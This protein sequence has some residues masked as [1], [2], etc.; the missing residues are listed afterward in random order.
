MFGLD[1]LFGRDCGYREQRAWGIWNR[2]YWE[3]LNTFPKPVKWHEDWY[4]L[5]VTVCSGD[6]KVFA[7][8]KSSTYMTIFVL[9]WDHIQHWV[10][11]DLLPTNDVTSMCFKEKKRK[12]MLMSIWNGW[13]IMTKNCNSYQLVWDMSK[14]WVAELFADRAWC[15]ENSSLHCRRVKLTHL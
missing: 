15:Q 9:H 13:R 1:L 2:D 6:N 12:S 4:L 8:Q 7:D 14:H 5:I 10:P 3:A 11:W